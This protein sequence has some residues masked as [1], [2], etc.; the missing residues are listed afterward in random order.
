MPPEGVEWK[1]HNNMLSFEET[2][3]LCGLMASLGIRKIK[4]TG[5]EPLVRR[6]TAAF[7]RNLKALPG[8]EKITLTTNGILLGAYLDEAK[9]ANE[10][11][12][13][14]SL[15]LDGVNISLNALNPELYKQMSRYEGTGPALILSLI[16]RLLDKGITVKLNC[17]IIRSI[18]EDEILPI[19]VM[20]KSKNITVRF[21]EFMPMG[22]AETLK[23]VSGKEIA[24]LLEKTYGTLTP[25]SGIQGNGPAV[26]Y[27]LPG[28]TGKIGFINAVTHGFCETCNRLRLTSEGFLKPCLANELS[29]DLREML[30]S[31]ASDEDL[32]QA[33][34]E[35]VLKKPRF[36][37][38]SKVYG[39]S[40]AE[41]HVTSMSCIGG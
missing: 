17:V 16:D 29:F 22:S 19:S 39:M 27:S 10:V 7:L 32:K 13:N 28:F 31:G 41:K 34:K 4:I 23:L 8:I 40:A 1:P 18:N 24:R 3:R 14:Q 20:A 26:Y 35:A 30:R 37:A 9:T 12:Q 6:G 33:V 2:L 36:H 25:F 38:L 5:G 15:S 11:Q 21:I